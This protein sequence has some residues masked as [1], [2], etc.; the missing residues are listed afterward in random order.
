MAKYLTE[1]QLE[2]IESAYEAKHPTETWVGKW[3]CGKCGCITT[4]PGFVVPQSGLPCPE[5]LCADCESKEH[6]TEMWE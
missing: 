4:D 2:A 1:K 5:A 6:L 3:I